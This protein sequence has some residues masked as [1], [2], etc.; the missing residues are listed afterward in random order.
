MVECMRNVACEP[1]DGE[2][3][4]IKVSY[5]E[6]IVTMIGKKPYYEI[7][8]KKIGEDYYH[9]GY[10]SYKLENVLAWRDECFEIVRETQ[11]NVGWI[12]V[13][14]HVMTEKERE[15]LGFPKS[16]AYYLDCK[17]PDDGQEI[18][19]TNGK[20]VWL[21]TCF[22]DD[23]YSLDSGNDWIDVTAWMPL[24]E[25]YSAEAEKPQTNADRV[26][27]MTDGELA[28]WFDAV[29]KDVLGGSTWDKN[30][31]LKW[32]QAE[33]EGANVHECD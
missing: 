11:S 7:E 13:K 23:G 28:K 27:N 22:E 15:E 25:P 21:D 19:V 1:Q 32:L 31:W 33:S 12:P 2:S 24:P 8:Y 5:L 14:Y 9:V 10:S 4:R 18:L 16:I 29:T 26:R 20:F 17:M 6:I 3:K 30:G